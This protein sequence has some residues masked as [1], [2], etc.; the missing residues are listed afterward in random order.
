MK[1][2][3]RRLSRVADSSHY[4]LLRSD[5]RLSLRSHSSLKTQRHGG[6]PEGHL[7]VYVGDD[8]ERFVVSAHLLSHPVFINLLNKSAQ[9]YGYQQQGVLRIPCHALLFERLLEALRLGQEA[10]YDQLQL[11]LSD[12]FLC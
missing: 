11:L 6:V 5:S 12:E 9:E 3:I 1:K 8:M 7:P 4:S 10:S 2:L